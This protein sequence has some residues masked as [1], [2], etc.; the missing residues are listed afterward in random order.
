MIDWWFWLEGASILGMGAALIYTIADHARVVQ[1]RVEL[2]RYR[3]LYIVYRRRIRGGH[4][5]ETVALLRELEDQIEG[6]SR[7][8]PD[9]LPPP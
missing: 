1:D 2:E 3:C 6:P 4:P 5:A 7:T 8:L 9:G